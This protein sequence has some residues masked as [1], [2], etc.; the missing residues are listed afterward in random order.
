MKCVHKYDIAFFMTS[1]GEKE[2]GKRSQLSHRREDQ[3]SHVT[4]DLAVPM[5]PATPQVD[6]SLDTNRL[7]PGLQS[8]PAPISKDTQKFISFAGIFSF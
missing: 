8:S 7:D 3:L 2:E 6:H 5:S 4:G 1:S